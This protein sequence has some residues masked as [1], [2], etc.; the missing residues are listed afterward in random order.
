MTQEKLKELLRRAF[1]EGF[2]VSREGF[3]GE[4]AIDHLAPDGLSLDELTAITVDGIM[5]DDLDGPDK[6]AA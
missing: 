3:N 2:A 4:F 6:P 1:L 5:E